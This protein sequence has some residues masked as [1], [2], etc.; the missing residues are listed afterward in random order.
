METESLEVDEKEEPPWEVR[1]AEKEEGSF[2]L[3]PKAWRMEGSMGGDI[4]GGWIPD[5]GVVGADVCLGAPLT[6]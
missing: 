5:V 2:G 1:L 3:R 4:F 6:R